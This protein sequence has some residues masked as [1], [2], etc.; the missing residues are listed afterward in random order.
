MLR[1]KCIST[2]KFCLPI[3]KEDAQGNKK[4]NGTNIFTQFFN[5]EKKLSFS[6]VLFSK[7]VLSN[8]DLYPYQLPVIHI[9]KRQS[10]Q[11]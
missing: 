6:L 9:A 5:H 4:M 1:K 2:I 3:F 11:A 7:K 10:D 8:F